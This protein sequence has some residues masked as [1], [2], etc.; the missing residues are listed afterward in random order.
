[1]N[2]LPTERVFD[3]LLELSYVDLMGVCGTNKL[4]WDICNDDGFWRRK[5]LRDFGLT[6]EDEAEPRSVYQ[7]LYFGDRY[8]EN[9]RYPK[10]YPLAEAFRKALTNKNYPFAD[11][12]INNLDLEDATKIIIDIDRDY[13]YR[14]FDNRFKGYLKS[15]N[16]LYD[17]TER[18]LPADIKNRMQNIILDQTNY[19]INA[20]GS[21]NHIYELI[22]LSLK[23]KRYSD[24]LN[25]EITKLMLIDYMVKRTINQYNDILVK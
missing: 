21:L 23:D 13:F 18:G 3:I 7:E 24:M 22:G 11:H 12:L 9:M 15:L 10:D 4:F 17:L 6:F 25:H 2:E 8:L 16:N 19:S 5:I 20:L 1:M 14:L